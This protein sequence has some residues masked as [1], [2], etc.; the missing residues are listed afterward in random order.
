MNWFWSL[1]I[2]SILVAFNAF[3]AESMVRMRHDI[4]D[5]H[6]IVVALRQPSAATAV[7]ASAPPKPPTPKT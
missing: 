6:K 1:L 7:A 4:R 3:A 5:I 2:V